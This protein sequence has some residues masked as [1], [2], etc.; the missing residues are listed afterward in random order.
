LVFTG[1][2]HRSHGTILSR[3]VVDCRAQYWEY[4]QFSVARSRVKNPHHLRVFL[5]E[6]L[7]KPEIRVPVAQNVVR[8]VESM[9]LPSALT[10]PRDCVEIQEPVFFAPTSIYLPDDMPSDHD[11]G[12]MMKLETRRQILPIIHPDGSYDPM[13]LSPDCSDR[14]GISWNFIASGRTQISWNRIASDPQKF[15]RRRFFAQSSIS[16]PSHFQT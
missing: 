15:L 8:I 7:D 14:K 9:I 2:V 5:P 10:I 11:S 12:P 13:G 1:T 16:A 4:G 6:D 3:A